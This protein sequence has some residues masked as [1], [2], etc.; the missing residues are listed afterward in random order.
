MLRL[1]RITM[2]LVAVIIGV[3]FF[4]NAGSARTVQYG[5]P[6]GFSY[7]YDAPQMRPRIA[8]RAKLHQRGTAYRHRAITE[9]RAYR[10]TTA[11]R[12]KSVALRKQVLHRQHVQYNTRKSRRVALRIGH[13]AL[14]NGRISERQVASLGDVPSTLAPSPKSMPASGQL[15]ARV[16]IR[17]Q[18]MTV[19]LNGEVLHVWKV[20]TGRSGFSTPRGSYAPQR[21]HASYFSKKYYNSPMPY[22]IFFRGGYAVHGTSAVNRLGGPASHGCVRLH[23]ANARQLFH[24]VQRYGPGRARI[25]IS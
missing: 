18:R 14:R 22:S 25:V 2:P 16:D 11:L 24:L 17:T 7:M 4:P 1:P 13:P 3:L 12:N 5:A 19:K 20:S 21:L 10:K 9:R 15:E 23:T 8:P 6:D